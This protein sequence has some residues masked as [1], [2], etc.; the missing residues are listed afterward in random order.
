M[1]VLGVHT[2]SV[3]AA[4]VPVLIG[5]AWAHAGNGWLF[6][7]PKGGWEYPGFLAL[8]AVVVALQGG[9]RYTL[10]ALLGQGGGALR[11]APGRA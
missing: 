10:G 7:A 9:G 5:A 1:L 2:R 3:A 11:T 6:S 8:A 4:L